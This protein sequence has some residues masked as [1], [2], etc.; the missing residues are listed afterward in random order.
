LFSN[1]E[2]ILEKSFLKNNPINWVKHSEMQGG[3]VR[4]SFGA[5]C[6]WLEWPAQGRIFSST[7]EAAAGS[8]A[9]VQRQLQRN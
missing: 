5:T 7:S 3:Q 9:V 6:C 4:L 1:G 2:D 8:N